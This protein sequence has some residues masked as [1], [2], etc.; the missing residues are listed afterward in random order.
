MYVIDEEANV[1]ENSE[2]T[3]Y[4]APCCAEGKCAESCAQMDS[5]VG[6]A[7]DTC[8]G[9]ILDK[10]ID[11][12]VEDGNRSAPPS[13]VIDALHTDAVGKKEEKE[14]S[15]T[16]TVGDVQFGV[17]ACTEDVQA[18]CNPE[19][20]LMIFLQANLPDATFTTFLVT[21]TLGFQ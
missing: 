12:V 4:S 13:T 9:G 17:P 14:K 11:L 18:F 19:E 3:N 8:I 21:K 5:L 20:A 1:C 15:F 2:V 16:L 6:G 7:L 10:M